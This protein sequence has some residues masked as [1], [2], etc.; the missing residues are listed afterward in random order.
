MTDEPK[1]LKINDLPQTERPRERLL[2]HGAASLATAELLAILLRT[3]TA[4]ENAV[5]LSERIVTYFGDLGRLA[6]ATPE[7]LRRF[8]GL[9][10]AKAAQLLAAIEIGRRIA[11]RNTAERPLVE[12]AADA[13]RLVDDM[14]A[15]SQEQVRVILLD[16][17]RRMIAV[18][19]VYIG[20]L[21]ATV[22]RV[23]ELFREAVTRSAAAMIVAHNHPS[24]DA[25]PSPEDVSVTR[26]L[27]AAGELLDIQVVDHLILTHDRW[28]SLREQGLGFDNRR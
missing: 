24:G 23:S 1:R 18:K 13:A 26:T 25:R 2:Q 20:T 4:D 28:T 10:D 3:G 8:K 6:A 9:G 12:C 15:L 7:E 17:A 27:V 19:T 5:R 22:L 21:N 14:G 11:T 16:S